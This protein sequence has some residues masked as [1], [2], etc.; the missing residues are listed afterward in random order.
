MKPAL[1]LCLAAGLT[2][3]GPLY[4]QAMIEYGVGIGRAGTAGAATG[5]GAAGIFSGLKG[6]VDQ[7]AKKPGAAQPR[8]ATAEELEKAKKAEKESKSE[9]A[10]ETKPGEEK[11][12]KAAAPV[13]WDAGTLTTSS[14]FVISGLQRRPTRAAYG[15]SSSGPVVQVASAET[16][17]ASSSDPA[18]P[19]AADSVAPAQS[20]SGAGHA[21]SSSGVFQPIVT[22]FGDARVE[23]P[24][25][26]AA[27]K[28]A[29]S[30]A[31]DIPIGTPVDE[32]LKRFGQ[33]LLALTGISGESYTE[34]YVF[35]MPDGARVTVLSVDGKV[36][37]VAV[38]TD[39]G[40]RAA[41]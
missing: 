26:G 30:A 2:A 38:E 5:A 27:P 33:P 40:T 18:A 23:A 41:L 28:D 36:T 20:G 12:E 14:G 21:S 25:P 13:S 16:P 29:K 34:K 1:M 6:S 22:Q 31:V 9:K 19:I 35:K 24:Q 8:Q 32:L 17:Q 39:P 3:S 15:P 7:A 10:A 37:T 4:G 11:E